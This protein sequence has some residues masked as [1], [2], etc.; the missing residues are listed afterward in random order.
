MKKEWAGG[1]SEVGYDLLRVA[2]RVAREYLSTVVKYKA[3]MNSNRQRNL[4]K[5]LISDIEHTIPS[6]TMLAT[7]CSTE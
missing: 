3:A 7:L 2:P 5:Q 1:M 4:N 6:S